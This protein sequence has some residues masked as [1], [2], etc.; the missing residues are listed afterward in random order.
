MTTNDAPRLDVLCALHEPCGDVQGYSARWD[1]YFCDA[2]DV[3][4]E[5]GCDDETCAFCALRPEKPS[6]AD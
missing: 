5:A 3:W 1:A 2:C 4:L 6:Q